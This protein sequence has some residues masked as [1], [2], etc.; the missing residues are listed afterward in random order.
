MLL[1]DSLLISLFCIFQMNHVF[2]TYLGAMLSLGMFEHPSRRIEIINLTN[3]TCQFIER[4]RQK[5]VL[6]LNFFSTTSQGRRDPGRHKQVGAPRPLYLPDRR[7]VRDRSLPEGY[8]HLHF[9][10]VLP[11]T[12][13]VQCCGQVCGHQASNELQPGEVFE[14]K[15]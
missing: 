7:Q 13:Y 9:P 8:P 5:A 12:G 2:V 10:A 3:I 6:E 1:F 11:S 15:N 14:P 4:K